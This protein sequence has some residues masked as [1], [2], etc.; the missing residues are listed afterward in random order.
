MCLLLF[1]KKRKLY[2]LFE[3]K[4]FERTLLFLKPSPVR[5]NLATDQLSRS[6]RIIIGSIV[7][8]PEVR[9]HCSR[10]RGRIQEPALDFPRM[11]MMLWHQGMTLRRLC[12][13]VGRVN[14]IE[15][16]HVTHWS[17]FVE[18]IPVEKFPG[19]NNRGDA[20]RRELTP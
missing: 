5:W 6:S 11:T 18:N 2:N 4:T 8:W 15:I 10:T 19:W 12:F 1:Q 17:I 9:S 16:V 3:R 20:H 7:I 14:E 13:K